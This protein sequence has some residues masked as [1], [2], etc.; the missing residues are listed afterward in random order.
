MG[1]TASLEPATPGTT[2]RPIMISRMGDKVLVAAP[3]TH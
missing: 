3:R 1:V 2:S